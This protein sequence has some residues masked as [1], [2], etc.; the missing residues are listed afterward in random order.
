MWEPG[1]QSGT[2][3]PWVWFSTIK[4][5]GALCH[6]K[7][8]AFRN[9]PFSLNEISKELKWPTLND[10]K[11]DF[12]D[13]G[14]CSPRNQCHPDPPHGRDPHMKLKK[15]KMYRINTDCICYWPSS[16]IPQLDDLLRWF[17]ASDIKTILDFRFQGG[18][19]YCGTSWSLTE[20]S[21]IGTKQEIVFCINTLS[22]QVSPG[23]KYEPKDDHW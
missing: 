13:S 1:R 2:T 11:A 12:I 9:S 18:S 16:V 21:M 20:L 15:I 6:L 22:F 7:N 4:K 10:P 3:W 14:D 17:D 8:L 23:D 5:L 19:W